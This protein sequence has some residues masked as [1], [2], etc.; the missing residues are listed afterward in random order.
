MPGTPQVNGTLTR[1]DIYAAMMA[2]PFAGRPVNVPATQ[3]SSTCNAPSTPD[4]SPVAAAT[5]V[6]ER[7]LQHTLTRE[8]GLGEWED[9]HPGFLTD[10][11]AEI[12]NTG[13]P[14]RGVVQEAGPGADRRRLIAFFEVAGTGEHTH[15]TRK[16]TCSLTL[17]HISGTDKPP[18]TTLSPGLSSVFWLSHSLHTGMRT[19]PFA[20]VVSFY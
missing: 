3:M 1:R 9:G 8:C 11:N 5:E 10:S 19:F 12:V 4:P 20:F 13:F 17:A 18:L 16:Y 7:M 14:H 6:N 15:N 2:L